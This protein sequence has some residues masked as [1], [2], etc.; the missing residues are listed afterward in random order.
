MGESSNLNFNNFL[1]T[2][3]LDEL[4]ELVLREKDENKAAYI[5]KAIFLKSNYVDDNNRKLEG[6]AL[7]RHKKKIKEKYEN[8]KYSDYIVLNKNIGRKKY[9]FL[10]LL[11]IGSLYA[12]YFYKE[13]IQN[14]FLKKVEPTKVEQEE[15]PRNLIENEIAKDIVYDENNEKFYYKGIELS[16]KK[17]NSLMGIKIYLGDKYLK[18]GDLEKATFLYLEGKEM[19]KV[20]IDNK[21]YEEVSAKINTLK[22]LMP[23]YLDRKIKGLREKLNIS[24]EEMKREANTIIKLGKEFGIDIQSVLYEKQGDLYFDEFSLLQAKN[25]YLL[26]SKFGNGNKK[27]ELE[28]KIRNIEI[29]IEINAL[30]QEIKI[31]QLENQTKLINKKYDKVI[32][33]NKKLDENYRTLDI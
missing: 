10:G 23:D 22:D 7:T 28:E 1:M 26:S 20:L 3:T 24:E 4:L 12:G 30:L 18:E 27:I 13:D 29:L 31:L 33:L 14:L 25:Y 17:L 15:I 11:L 9:I 19:S 32:E 16:N 21:K 2:K 5:K 6:R 8:T